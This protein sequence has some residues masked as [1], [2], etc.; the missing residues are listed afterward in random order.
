MGKTTDQ[1]GV[2][3]G[4]QNAGEEL[5]KFNF[6][7]VYKIEIYD[8]YNQQ[9]SEMKAIQQNSNVAVLTLEEPVLINTKVMCFSGSEESRS[10]LSKV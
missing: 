5:T 6:Q 10:I 4:N 3:V 2:I 7:L 8:S 9:L 1:I